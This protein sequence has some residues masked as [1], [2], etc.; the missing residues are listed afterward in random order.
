M[1]AE[2]LRKINYILKYLTEHAALK[3]KSCLLILDVSYGAGN[4]SFAL[5]DAG[6]DVTG[7]DLDNASITYCRNSYNFIRLDFW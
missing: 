6:Y 7:I 5:L 3:G 4:I 2:N 1:D